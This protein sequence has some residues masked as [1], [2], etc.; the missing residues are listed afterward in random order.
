MFYFPHCC[1]YSTSKTCSIVITAKRVSSLIHNLQCVVNITQ[2]LRCMSCLLHDLPRSHPSSKYPEYFQCVNTSEAAYFQLWGVCVKGQL[3]I[4]SGPDSPEMMQGSCVKGILSSLFYPTSA[5][6]NK[7][8][9]LISD[10]FVCRMMNI[11]PS[12]VT[13]AP[14]CTLALTTSMGLVTVE[15]VAAASGPAMA[16]SSR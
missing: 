13:A 7:R 11:T 2:R 12:K 14:T 1:I 8:T 9:R 3:W 10:T 15:A 4:I 6:V 5:L 16:C